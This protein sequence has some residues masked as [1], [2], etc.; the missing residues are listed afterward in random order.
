MPTIICDSREQKWDHVQSYLERAGIRWLRSKLPV[1]DYGRMDNLS[2]VVDRKA[3]LSEVEGNLI[4]QH[5]RFRREAIR[6]QENGIRLIVLVE[7]GPRVKGL[8]DVAK[9]ENP[10]LKKWEELDKAHSMGKRLNIPISPRPPVSGSK[11]AQIMHTMSEKY[12][13]EWQFCSHQ[14][15]GKAILS[16]LGVEAHEGSSANDQGGIADEGAGRKPWRAY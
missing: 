15:A 9:W 8:G 13:L 11:L 5:D 14:E 2:V 10:R 12:G 6:A 16:I 7:A 1:G 3:S 4:Q